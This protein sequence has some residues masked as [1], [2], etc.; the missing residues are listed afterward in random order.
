MAA[1]A[2]EA[3]TLSEAEGIQQAVRAAEDSLRKVEAELEVRYVSVR[4][5]IADIIRIGCVDVLS[6]DDQLACFYPC[7]EGRVL[8]A[9]IWFSPPWRNKA[10]SPAVFL[11]GR[12]ARH[13]G[14]NNILADRTRKYY[15]EC[16][17]ASFQSPSRRKAGSD[18]RK[19]VSSHAACTSSLFGS[20]ALSS[21]SNSTSDSI[22]V[23][24][25]CHVFAPPRW[26]CVRLMCLREQD[27]DAVI[28]AVEDARAKQ[29]REA[30][31]LR[32]KLS[33]FGKAV[34]P[35][36]PRSSRTNGAADANGNGGGGPGDLSG[37]DEGER[38]DLVDSDEVQYDV[39]VF[40]FPNGSYQER[41]F[42]RRRAASQFRQWSCRPRGQK[43]CGGVATVG[44]VSFPRCC[45][46]S[47]YSSKM[48]VLSAQEL[49]SCCRRWP[50]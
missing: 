36:T 23:S 20:L 32:D 35:L 30:D 15:D 3:K 11:K 44:V 38:E 2:R 22:R 12:G 7:K 13:R 1:E 4:V 16:V 33:G 43:M 50:R 6:E 21:I 26:W 25:P 41:L 8:L 48:F 5:L 10:F 14:S 18:S 31:R 49:I 19:Y 45:R 34:T 42:Y 28:A 37:A 24:H 46:A 9:G 29:E 27:R 40:T 17:A 39:L 47:V